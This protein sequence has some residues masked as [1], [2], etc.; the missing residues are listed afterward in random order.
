M[1]TEEKGN[2]HFEGFYRKAFSHPF[3]ESDISENNHLG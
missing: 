1:A 2:M 3:L